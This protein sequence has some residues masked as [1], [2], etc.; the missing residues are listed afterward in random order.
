MI[1][2]DFK[3]D[4]INKNISY[5]T[6]GRSKTY[7]VK[8]FYSFIQDV[9]DEPQNMKYDIPIEAISKTEFKLINGWNMEE[10]AKKQLKGGTLITKP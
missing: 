8:E 5:I 9:F 2:K 3:I 6:K 1:N 4:F 7:S 10:K